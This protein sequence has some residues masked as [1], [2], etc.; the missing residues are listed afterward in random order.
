MPRPNLKPPRP[1][2]QKKT[3]DKAPHTHREYSGESPLAPPHPDTIK[4]VFSDTVTSDQGEAIEV[5]VLCSLV[6]SAALL[7]S[8]KL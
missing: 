2:Q 4:K 5:V 6:R 7:T 1:T 3:N 8:Q